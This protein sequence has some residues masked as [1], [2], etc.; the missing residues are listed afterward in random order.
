M[1]NQKGYIREGHPGQSRV[2]IIDMKCT[3]N[4]SIVLAFFAATALLVISSDAARQFTHRE[5][6][7]PILD[8]YEINAADRDTV[9]ESAGAEVA[10]SWSFEF[11]PI[12]ELHDCD[13]WKAAACSKD[14]TIL[15]GMIELCRDHEREYAY[16]IRKALE[17]AYCTKQWK[18]LTKIIK[19]M[20]VNLQEFES[21]I[22]NRIANALRRANDP[23]LEAILD[24]IAEQMD[25]MPEAI[26][27]VLV[28]IVIDGPERYRESVKKIHEHVAHIGLKNFSAVAMIE[29]R[30]ERLAALYACI[31]NENDW[32]QGLV[33]EM[34]K[35]TWQAGEYRTLGLLLKLEP[36]NKDDLREQA[37]NHLSMDILNDNLDKV[38]ELIRIF[39]ISTAEVNSVLKDAVRTCINV[40][41]TKMLDGLFRFLDHAV[42]VYNTS[43]GIVGRINPV[44]PEILG[45]IFR[46]LNTPQEYERVAN[47]VLE[48]ALKEDSDLFDAQSRKRRYQLIHHWIKGRFSP[49]GGN[50]DREQ[51][52]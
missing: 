52:G 47:A 6:V 15:D 34:A 31:E 2:K 1:Y 29:D 5:G 12:S 20:C 49:K 48:R 28:K 37:V 22:A 24:G 19:L 39:E 3:T 13:K 7:T 38:N 43:R 23:Y 42:G 17:A 4:V 51:D 26:G 14:H 41:S 21:G 27:K 11:D 50:G 46:F 25:Q 45:N 10:S 18:N 9:L 35:F 36:G 32:P 8:E 33:D 40:G 16:Q 30:K 44:F